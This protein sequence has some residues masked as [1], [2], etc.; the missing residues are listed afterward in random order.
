MIITNNQL[1]NIIAAIRSSFGFS[2]LEL[3]EILKVNKKDIYSL[4]NK[5]KTPNIDILIH[6]LIIYK[7]SLEWNK[8]SNLPADELMKMNIGGKNLFNMLKDNNF[9]NKDIIK[10]IKIVA[11]ERNK[12]EKYS[13]ARKLKIFGT[14]LKQNKERNLEF[15]T[16]NWFPVHFG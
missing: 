2:L 3:S 15:E 10:H 4:I 11:K 7:F 5:V 14:N 8:Y 13:K 12:I 9:K 1:Q 6:I 16:T